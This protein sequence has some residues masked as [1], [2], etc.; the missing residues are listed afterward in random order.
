MGAKNWKKFSDHSWVNFV[1]IKWTGRNQWNTQS[2]WVEKRAKEH[3][4]VTHKRWKI[5]GQWAYGN[6]FSY[7][8][9]VHEN[10]DEPVLCS[11]IYHIWICIRIYKFR[12]YPLRFYKSRAINTVSAW[13]ARSFLFIFYF[14]GNTLRVR[15]MPKSWSW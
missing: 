3:A 1:S 7:Q 2:S 13:E 10:N 8:R 14:L 12:P 15:D 11:S 9:H 5:N 4:W 6:A